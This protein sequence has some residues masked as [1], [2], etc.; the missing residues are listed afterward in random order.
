MKR[1]FFFYMKCKRLLLGLIFLCSTQVS[2]V[3]LSWSCYGLYPAHLLR[4]ALNKQ[5]FYRQMNISKLQTTKSY[6]LF[7]VM[8]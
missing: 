7:C 1:N 2:S 6:N 8:Y 5:T 4:S 3:L